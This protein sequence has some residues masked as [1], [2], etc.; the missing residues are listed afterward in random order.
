MKSILIFFI[1]TLIFWG[2]SKSTDTI[3]ASSNPGNHSNG[4]IKSPADSTVKSSDPSDIKKPAA[5]FKIIN[6][7]EAGNILELQSLIIKNTSA[8][9]TSYTWD[10][11][12]SA[13]YFDGTIDYPLR[14]SNKKEPENIY[15]VPCMQTVTIK[16]TASNNAGDSSLV[17]QSFEVYCFRGVGGRH[18]VMHKL[19]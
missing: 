14:F 4:S 18:P 9:A 13:N 1:A 12:T 5:G 2:C 17:S 11:G 6:L 16:L 19:Y 10:L 3:S 7:N 8:N 15:M